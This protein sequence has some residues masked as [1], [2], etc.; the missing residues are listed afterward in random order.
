MTSLPFGSVKITL[1]DTG[2]ERKFSLSVVTMALE[3]GF[4]NSSGTTSSVLPLLL[5]GVPPFVL[6]TKSVFR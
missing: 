1:P 6:D 3:P 5:I 4:G 2:L